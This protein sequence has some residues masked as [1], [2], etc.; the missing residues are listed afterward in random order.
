MTDRLSPV[1]TTAWVTLVVT[2]ILMCVVRMWWTM[3]LLFGLA[4]TL[5]LIVGKNRFCSDLC[6][7]GAL[8][9]SMGQSAAP[10]RRIASARWWKFLLVPLFWGATLYS[11]FTYHHDPPVLWVW[12]LRI[13]ISMF[14]L[15]MVTQMYLG[16][17]FFCVH[18]CPLRHPVLEPARRSRNHLLKKPR[19]F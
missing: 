12:M 18:L 10:R 15:A 19:H 11:T 2:F 9:D 13:M 14:F 4:L 3:F 17:R 8:Q 7:M 16:R 5:A 1:K 6:P